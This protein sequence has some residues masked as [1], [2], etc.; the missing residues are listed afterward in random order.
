[1]LTET[2]FDECA[3]ELETNGFAL[4]SLP[5]LQTGTTKRAENVVAGAFNSARRALDDTR[6][7][8]PVIDPTTDSGSWSGF[9]SATDVHGRYN[10]HREGFVFSNGEMFGSD[11]FQDDMKQLF[12]LMHDDV[13]DGVLRAIER[14]L[15][16][17]Q[18]YFQQE[19]GSTST[20]SQWHI[21]RYIV[22][23]NDNKSSEQ[24]ETEVLLPVHTDPSLIS[25]VIIDQVGKNEGGM[26]L[27][28][29][30]QRYSLQKTSTLKVGSWKEITQHG[31]D[32]AVIFVGSV[33]SY[34]TKGRV[35]SAT[36][37]RVINSKSSDCDMLHDNEEVQCVSK[38]RMAATLFVRPK[39]NAILNT[40]PSRH[41]M[42]IDDMVG[43]NEIKKTAPT[44]LSW[45]ARVAKNYVKRN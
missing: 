3:R 43:T 21:K 19:F 22:N 30:H 32:V 34:L 14:R 6:T 27:E 28:V 25:V 17:P 41:V 20:S 40:L 16:L 38:E 24:D 2:I 9:H 13:A 37:H 26:G 23:G 4:L 15:E 18:S 8:A 1:M 12:Q 5:A 31:H 44:F 42:V 45:N 7:K 10:R 36:R 29:F 33:L 39:G 11:D 35:Y